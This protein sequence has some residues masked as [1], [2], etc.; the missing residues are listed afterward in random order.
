MSGHEQDDDAGDVLSSIRRLV[1]DAAPPPSQLPAGRLVLTPALR[2]DTPTPANQPAQAH[3]RAAEE[4]AH[5]AAATPPQSPAT[6]RQ[7]HGLALQEPGATASI[8]PHAS[9]GASLERTIAELEAAV[10][11]SFDD[12]EAEDSDG[13]APIRARGH[14]AGDDIGARSEDSVDAPDDAR[15]ASPARTQADTSRD[16]DVQAHRDPEEARYADPDMPTEAE[17]ADKL[18]DL[19]EEED[20]LLD[21]EALR[22]LVA[23]VVR[24][25]LRGTLGERITRNVRKLVRSEVARAIASRDLAA[26]HNTGRDQD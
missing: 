25:E 18:A 2:V 12:W 11:A 15:A 9:D 3:A 16:Y 6:P 22:D 5:A 4:S 26:G 10:A 23:Q 14:A 8:S 19:A 1:T 17:T 21:E 24:E 20:L 13:V 7:P